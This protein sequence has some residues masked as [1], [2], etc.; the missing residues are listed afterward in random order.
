MYVTWRVV[1]QTSVTNFEPL[2]NVV[3]RTTYVDHLNWSH[4][5]NHFN[6]CTW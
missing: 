2:Y 6:D 3:A 1:N 4:I 5:D